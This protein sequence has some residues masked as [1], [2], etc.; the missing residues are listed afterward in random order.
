MIT[1]KR[2]YFYR[3]IGTEQL[4]TVDIMECNL[5]VFRIKKKTIN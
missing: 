2:E 4:N 1:Y 3:L 5:Q